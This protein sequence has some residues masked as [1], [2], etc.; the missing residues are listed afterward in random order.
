MYLFQ[1]PL[2]LLEALIEL[3]PH[4]AGRR[5]GRGG[6]GGGVSLL[7]AGRRRRRHGLRRRHRGGRAGAVPLVVEHGVAE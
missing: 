6:G 2:L 1:L 4:A 5:P 7:A 3:R